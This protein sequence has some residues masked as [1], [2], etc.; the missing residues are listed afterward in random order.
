M[1][2]PKASRRKHF[3]I[4]HSE[5]EPLTRRDIQFDLLHHIFANSE[6]VFTDPNAPSTALSP[7]ASFRDVYVHALMQSSRTARAQRDKMHDLPD[8]ATDFAKISLLTNV[9]RVNTTMTFLPEMRTSL[10]TYHPVPALQQHDANLQ[11][12]P[13]IKNMLK[14]CSIRDE[15][16]RLPVTP[17]ELRDKTNKGVVPSTSI[18]NLIFVLS[19]HFTAI[20]E[21]HFGAQDIDFL[22]LFLPTKFSSASRARAFLWLIFKYHEGA[23][24]NPFD[25]APSHPNPNLIPN[26]EPITE[27]QFELENVDTPPEKDYG[28]KMSKFRLDFLAK[29]AEAALAEETLPDKDKKGKGKGKGKGRQ[30]PVAQGKKRPRVDP[31]PRPKLEPDVGQDD[32]GLREEPPA[33]RRRLSYSEPGT[34]RS[35]HAPPR[36]PHSLHPPNDGQWRIG[37]QRTVLQRKRFPSSI[38]TD[39]PFTF[40]F[41]A[42]AWH[43]V[44]AVDPLEDSDE[45]GDDGSRHAY[46]QYPFDRGLISALTVHPDV[47]IRVLEGLDQRAIPHPLYSQHRTLP[48]YS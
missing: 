28:A 11:D 1:A 42:D 26:L 25:D 10:R 12:A 8:F 43:I 20:A 45:E 36:R 18:V 35:R 41:R 16:S 17:A 3:A 24:P 44:S 46:S 2:A 22:D 32:V 38:H 39:H 4:K 33:R 34:S 19:N 48:A 27:E 23:T 40:P 31:D 29:N 7:R 21:D 5:A 37:P 15:A 9:G 13:R 14:A 6:Q 47:R 30:D